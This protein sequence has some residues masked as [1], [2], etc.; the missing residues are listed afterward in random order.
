M[1]QFHFF[2]LILPNNLDFIILFFGALNFS[3]NYFKSNFWKNIF[4]K[5]KIAM[6]AEF[7]ELVEAAKCINSKEKNTGEKQRDEL[8]GEKR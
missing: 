2:I 8:G 7:T 5:M 6:I 4:K 3:F 1:R